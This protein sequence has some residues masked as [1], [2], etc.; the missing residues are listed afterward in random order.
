MM[1]NAE[2]IV[3]SFIAF[4]VGFILTWLGTIDD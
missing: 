3:V 1:T 2:L 4:I